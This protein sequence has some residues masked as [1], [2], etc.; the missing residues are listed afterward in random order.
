MRFGQITQRRIIDLVEKKILGGLSWRPTLA[1]GWMIV[2]F[3][4]C[5][6]HF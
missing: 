1:L 6:E 2:W 5:F 4:G 3:L